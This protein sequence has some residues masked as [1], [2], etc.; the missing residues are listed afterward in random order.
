MRG[1]ALNKIGNDEYKSRSMKYKS[2]RQAMVVD[3]GLS[4]ALHYIELK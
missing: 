2:E 1:W 4:A 3:G